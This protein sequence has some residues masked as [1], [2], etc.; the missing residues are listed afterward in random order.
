MRAPLL[1]AYRTAQAPA[2]PAFDVA[3]VADAVARSCAA[4]PDWRDTPVATRAAILRR[5]ADAMEAQ[6]PSLCALLVKEAFKT[7]GDCVAE[8]R[9]AVDFLRY[10]AGEAERIM[11]ASVCG[12]ISAISI[13]LACDAMMVARSN[14]ALPCVWSPLACVFTT[15]PMS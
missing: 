14:R 12:V 2:L 11:P 9:E 13:A 1:A 6:L 3:G 7:W 5:G 4:Y 15:V 10:Y 8:V